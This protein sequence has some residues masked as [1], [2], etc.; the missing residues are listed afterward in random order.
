MPLLDRVEDKEEVCL[1]DHNEFS[2][3]ADNIENAKIVMVIDHHKIDNFRTK[4]PLEYIAKPVGC[5]S[6]TIYEMLKEENVA[7]KKEVLEMLLSAI[8][9]DTLLLKSPTTTDKDIKVANEIASI[10][11]ID[12]N[13]YGFEL[14][15]A[16]ADLSDVSDE[17]L[18]N[19]DSKIFEP[20]SLKIEI[21]QINAV[22]MDSILSR[23]IGIE[24]AM[25][26]AIE[27]K[28]LDAFLVAV[29]DVINCNSE[30]I[31]LGSRI[32]II[33]KAFNVSL[34]NNRAFLE[35]VVSRKKQLAPPIMDAAN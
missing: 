4:E 17:G 18:I 19:I 1:V 8:I 14:L 35:G 29:T 28:G 26:K 32:D 7:D 3:S 2:Q 11:N 30:I 13:E 34:N 12:L 24:D 22:D 6:T 27:S 15:K 20:N 33:E 31:A 16:G 25:K 21:A 10:L 23:Q 9:S 5:N